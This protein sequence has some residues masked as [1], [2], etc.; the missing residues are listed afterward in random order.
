[1]LCYTAL[2]FDAVETFGAFPFGLAPS[3]AEWFTVTCKFILLFSFKNKNK[4]VMNVV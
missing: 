2:S 1:M 4:K 3:K